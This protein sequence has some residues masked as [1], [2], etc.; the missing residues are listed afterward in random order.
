MRNSQKSFHLTILIFWIRNVKMQMSSNVSTFLLHMLSLILSS[1]QMRLSNIANLEIYPFRAYFRLHILLYGRKL[2]RQLSAVDCRNLTPDGLDNN[3][4]PDSSMNLRCLNIFHLTVLV[5]C[6]PRQVEHPC[7]R[8]TSS[9]SH[10]PSH[11]PNCHNPEHI[12]P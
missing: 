5:L 1:L 11:R 3:A 8:V 4:E 2:L 6:M 7:F 10:L 9:S 12:T